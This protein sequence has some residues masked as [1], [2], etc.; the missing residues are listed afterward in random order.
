MGGGGVGVELLWVELV[1]WAPAVTVLGESL[2]LRSR[3][4]FYWDG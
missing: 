1:V 3:T 4:S 2:M